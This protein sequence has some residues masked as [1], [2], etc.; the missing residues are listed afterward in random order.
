MRHHGTRP[1]TTIRLRGPADILAVLPYQLGFHPRDSIVAVVLHGQRLGMIA[2]L[3]LP[4]EDH[5]REAV[6]AMVG[7]VCRELP[8]R[9]L[10]VGY[11]PKP[12]ASTAALEV[13]TDLLD[14]AGVEVSDV[15]V[16]RGGRWYDGPDEASDGSR[17]QPVPDPVEVPAVADFVG[18]GRSAVPDRSELLTRLL[19]ADDE[20][21]AAVTDRLASLRTR[22]FG[23]P[24]PSIEDAMVVW[25]GLI[26]GDSRAPTAREVAVLAWSLRDLQ[27]RDALIAVLC[28]GTLPLAALDLDVVRRL[29]AGLRSPA[30]ADEE[31]AESGQALDRAVERLSGVCRTLPDGEAAP[32][33]TVLANLLWWRGDGALARVALDRALDCEEDYRLAQLLLRMVDLAIRPAGAAESGST[34]RTRSA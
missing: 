23:Q 15:F 11:E 19:P 22:V 20:Q 18:L 4:P 32:L 6:A 27:V 21:V 13:V 34:A 33:L 26:A 31:T 2:R 24:G 17:G 10:L 28:P 5:T 1:Q 29:T 7:P 16:V 8:D 9:V 3:D 30:W 25:D 14:L 12:G